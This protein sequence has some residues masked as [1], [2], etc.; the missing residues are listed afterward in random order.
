MAG[1]LDVFYAVGFGREG[2]VLHKLAGEA[3]AEGKDGEQDGAQSD[4]I[5][6]KEKEK[7]CFVNN[8]WL[9]RLQR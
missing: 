5:F 9:F 1:P 2:I 6:H 3:S 7:G 4:Q 8:M